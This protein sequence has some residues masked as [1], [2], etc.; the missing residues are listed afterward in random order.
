MGASR[1][2]DPPKTR[3]GKIKRPILRKISENDIVELCG[4]T[5]AFAASS[6][7]RRIRPMSV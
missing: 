1:L 5:S 3:S 6:V 4:I 7:D 2:P